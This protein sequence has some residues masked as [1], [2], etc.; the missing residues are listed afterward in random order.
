MDNREAARAL[1]AAASLLESEG[2]NPYRVRAYRRAAAGLLALPVGALG[3]L[4]PD[5]QVQLPWLGPRLRRKL[6]ELLT[7]GRM[8]FYDEV[9]GAL[10]PAKRDLLAVEGIGPKTAR[11]LSEELGLQSAAEVAAAARQGRLQQLR[12]IG[13]RREAQLGDAAAALAKS[14]P[15]RTLPADVATAAVGTIERAVPAPSGPAPRPTA[16]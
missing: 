13:A 5:G 11:R 8:Q 6:G 10:P 15:V 3:F 4:A 1:F 14:R 16:A 7:S 2:A 12:G 9:V